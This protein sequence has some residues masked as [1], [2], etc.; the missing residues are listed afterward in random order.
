[1]T[2]R[3]ALDAPSWREMGAAAEVELNDGRMLKG[4]LEYDDMTA[5]PDEQPL[6]YFKSGDEKISW[7]DDVKCFRLLPA[8]PSAA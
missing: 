5:G 1:M 4:T 7:Y 3:P 6:V 2:W 8:G